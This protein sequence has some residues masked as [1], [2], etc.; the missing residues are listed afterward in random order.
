M[1]HVI[2]VLYLLYGRGPIT[3]SFQDMDHCKASGQILT[4]QIK[5]ESFGT[6]AEYH[7]PSSNG[8]FDCVNVETGEVFHHEIRYNIVKERIILND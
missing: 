5:K 6:D 1:G 3:H 4:R 8:N 7:L 2:L